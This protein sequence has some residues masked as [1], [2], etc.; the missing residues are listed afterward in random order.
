M[1]F[2]VCSLQ[3]AVCS[4]QFAVCSLQFA[5]CSLQFAVLIIAMGLK[6][7]AIIKTNSSK[8]FTVFTLGHTIIY[9][10]DIQILILYIK[11][12]NVKFLP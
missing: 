5:V 7:I 9:L 2:A 8:T 12:L 3:F 4:L 1:Q 10:Y 6:P 11:F